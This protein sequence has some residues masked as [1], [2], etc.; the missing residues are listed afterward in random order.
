[1]LRATET[2]FGVIV[3][4]AVERWLDGKKKGNL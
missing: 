2:D 4:M 3:K 1:M